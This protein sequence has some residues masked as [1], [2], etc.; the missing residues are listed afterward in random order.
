MKEVEQTEQR[1]RGVQSNEYRIISITYGNRQ[2]AQR[3]IRIYEQVSAEDATFLKLQGY[4]LNELSG[5]W[6]LWQ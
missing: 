1:F 4:E 5:E 3:L 6:E 2:Q